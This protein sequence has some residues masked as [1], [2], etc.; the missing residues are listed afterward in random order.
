MYPIMIRNTWSDLVLELHKINTPQ[1]KFFIVIDEAIFDTYSDDISKTF[2]ASVL[3]NQSIT[4]FAINVEAKS[5]ATTMA[6]LKYFHEN[7]L[8]RSSLVVAIGGG[9]I[10]DIAGFAASIYMRGI[11]YITLPTTLLSMVDA[12]IGGKTG[13]DFEGVKNLI[14]TFHNP[15]LVYINVDTLKSLNHAQY[16]S[17]LAEVIKYGIISDSNFFEYISDHRQE[18]ASRN[19]EA[20]E[21]IINTSISIKSKIVAEDA[22]DRGIRQILNY[23]HTFGHA[24]EALCDF[25]LPHG[26]CVALGIICAANFSKN[27]NMMSMFHVEH[28]YDILSFFGLPTKLPKKFKL[29]AEDIYQK[30][31]V[32]KK[33]ENGN[34]T[35]IISHKIGS[36]NIHRG[37][38]KDDVISAIKSILWERPPLVLV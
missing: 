35:L 19:P 37:A 38:E 30:M 14:G 11:D 31:L 10:S 5:I 8:D 22:K 16:I 18:V 6:L 28:I 2:R 9:A 1:R 25:K 20:L 12:S 13:V 26:H 32:D 24:I 15:S 33:A 34:I 17:G 27:M 29:T 23:G 21:K 7:R 3:I 36:A 4:I